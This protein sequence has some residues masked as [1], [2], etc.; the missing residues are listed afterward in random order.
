MSSQKQIEANRRNAQKSTG[1][2]TP[3]GK[4]A[5]SMNALKTGLYAMSLI[6]RDERR[7]DFEK[8]TAEYYGQYQPTTADFRDLVDDLVMAVWQVRRLFE[9]EAMIENHIRTEL[10][11][12]EASP[13]G[14]VI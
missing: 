12:P 4:S 2:V 13:R 11:R 9:T 8:L 7:A 3:A 1:P 10:Y 14:K 6:T 5:S